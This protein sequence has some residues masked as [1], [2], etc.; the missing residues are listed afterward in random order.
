M[1]E[2]APLNQK[3]ARILTLSELISQLAPVS[4]MPEPSE[5]RRLRSSAG[6]TQDETALALGVTSRQVTRYESGI[7]S[8]R[9]LIT[10]RYRS[11]L[12]AFEFFDTILASKCPPDFFGRWRVRLI[13]RNSHPKVIS[14][15]RGGATRPEIVTVPCP[16]CG[17]DAG[18][19]C[20]GPRGGGRKT[21]H[22]VRG[23]AY[24]AARTIDV[25]GEAARVAFATRRR[26]R[27]Q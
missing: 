24:M 6:F 12:A 13:P 19:L 18:R 5:R 3:L 9:P 26:S 1:S 27:A 11:A 7:A 8:P 25:D 17:A 21:L 10:D 15:W 16:E 4:E 14:I 22:Q 2:A 20:I 23:Q